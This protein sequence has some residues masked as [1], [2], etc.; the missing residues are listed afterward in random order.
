MN[1]LVGVDMTKNDAGRQATLDL[2]APLG[3]NSLSNFGG[4]WNAL[5]I[6]GEFA[7]FIQQWAESGV[8]GERRKLRA[9][10]MDAK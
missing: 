10:Q 7:L 3:E 5:E 2:R 6:P 4:Q 8:G 1:E 9:I